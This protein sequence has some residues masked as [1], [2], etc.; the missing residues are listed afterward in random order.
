V[1]KTLIKQNYKAGLIGGALYAAWALWQ[2][3]HAGMSQAMV[4]ATTQFV[5]SFSLAILFMAYMRWLF[6]RGASALSKFLHVFLGTNVA[7]LV[8]LISI[9]KLMGTPAI[10]LTI[11]PN[12]S[13]ALV[14]PVVF[15]FQAQRAAKSSDEVLQ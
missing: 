14:L 1:L 3:W 9:H 7:A 11:A 15:Y 4:S 10:L 13:M 6:D 2:N 8:Y 5:L 12:M